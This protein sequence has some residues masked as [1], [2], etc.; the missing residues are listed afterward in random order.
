MRRHLV[1]L[2]SAAV[3]FGCNAQIVRAQTIAITGGMVYPVSG[4]PITNGTVLIRNGKIAEVGATVV[5]PADAQRIDAT[6]KVVTPGLINAYT[7]LGVDE[8]SGVSET[9]DVQAR[10]TD[11]IAAAFRVWDGLNSNSALIGATRNEGITSVL[12]APVGGLVSGQAA[13]VDLLTGRSTEMLRRTPAAMVVQLTSPNEAGTDARGEMIA[14]LRALLDDAVYYHQ[15]RTEYD[16]RGARVLTA[17]R[18]DLEALTPVITGALP[19]AIL[20]DRADDLD[21]ALAI[22]RDYH[23]KLILFGAAEGWMRASA[24]SAANVP[25][26]VGAMNN[27]PN[28]FSMLHA[29][30]DNAALLRKAGVRVAMM[31]NAGDSDEEQFNVR[32]V[33]YEAGNAVSYGM[34]HDDAL[35]AV[36]LTPAELFGAAGQVGSLQVGKDANVVIWSGDPFEFSTRVE[37]VLIRGR[38][39]L[40]ASR[41]DMLEQ[42]YRTLPP[43]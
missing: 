43:Q 42:R 6:G 4:A 1:A 41:Q 20:A 19:L 39:E 11:A 5:I 16:K 13:L 22:A 18:A 29:R 10:G 37:H 35:R 9:R 40:R 7:A 27:I 15:H 25:V 30:Q 33:K 8:V 3:A 28:T 24:I 12:V 32:N 17:S 21:A 23:L 2:L 14:K 38:E 34:P 26:V 36:T 31:G